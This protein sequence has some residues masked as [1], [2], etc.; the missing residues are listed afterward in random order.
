MAGTGRAPKAASERRN[1][2]Q[3]RRG[4]WTELRPLENPEVP[5]LPIAPT[6]H[7]WS[8]RTIRAWGN[9]WRDPAVQMWGGADLDLVE[10]LAY[11]HEQWAIKGTTGL[12]SEIRYLRESLGLT[13]KGK[14]DRRWKVAPPAEVLDIEDGR[15]AAEKMK[16]LRDRAASAEGST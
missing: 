10:H 3:P 12:L 11:V 13:P 15:S 5:D 2:N 16:E 7:G 1:R 6:E 14:Q 8:E 4:D 9:W